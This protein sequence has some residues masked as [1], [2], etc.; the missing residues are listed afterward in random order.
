M[1]KTLIAAP[2]VFNATFLVCNQQAASQ[3]F[4]NLKAGEA[5]I[6]AI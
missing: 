3:R 2:N 1:H 6:H 4:I 5:L